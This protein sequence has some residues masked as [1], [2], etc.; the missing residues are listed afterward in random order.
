[1]PNGRRR[2]Q[3]TRNANR[4]RNR[5]NDSIIVASPVFESTEPIIVQSQSITELEDKLQ[6]LENL[7][8]TMKENRKKEV[9]KFVEIENKL[10]KLKNIEK[11]YQKLKSQFDIHK[12]LCIQEQTLNIRYKAKI[13]ELLIDLEKAQNKYKNLDEATHDVTSSTQE[14]MDVTIQNRVISTDLIIKLKRVKSELPTNF[15]TKEW[16]NKHFVN[17]LIDL[18]LDELLKLKF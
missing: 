11:K 5:T 3:N 16:N 14:L 10:N 4:N 8:N 6:N 13:K 15:D 2:Q 18:T 9:K 1:M 17:F 12:D 7:V